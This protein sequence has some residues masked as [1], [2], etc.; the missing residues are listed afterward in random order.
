MTFWWSWCASRKPSPLAPV[1]A[2]FDGAL[3]AHHAAGPDVNGERGSAGLLPARYS[4]EGSF[5]N[6]LEMPAPNC[7]AAGILLNYVPALGCDSS[8]GRR[9]GV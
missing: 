8:D 4:C 5:Q 7:A 2:F 3:L 6:R 9:A 1:A